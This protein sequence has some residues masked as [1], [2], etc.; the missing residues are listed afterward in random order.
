LDSGRLTTNRYA[1]FL[2]N[3]LGLSWVGQ[4]QSGRPYPI[5]TGSAGFGGS[6]RFFGAGS[7]T[8]Q[9]PNVAPDG[10]VNTSSIASFYGTN[11]LFGPGPFAKC[12][13]AFPT[14]VSQCQGI[15]NA[16]AAPAGVTNTGAFD[17]VTGA[18]V[19]F[20]SINGNLG[21]DV[22]RGSPFVRFDASLHK[23]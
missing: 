8:Q 18:P 2:A 4:L 1:G 3:N 13:A 10:T 17:V 11:A 5:S 22:G 6:G 12:I 14:L 19:T 21:R 23:S 9:R 15:Q 16:Q 20:K 7:E